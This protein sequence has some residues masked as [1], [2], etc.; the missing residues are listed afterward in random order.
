MILIQDVDEDLGFLK[1][2]LEIRLEGVDGDFGLPAVETVEK[3][4]KF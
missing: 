2:R 4:M 1:W 3:D